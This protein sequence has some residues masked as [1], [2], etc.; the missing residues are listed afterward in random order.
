MLQTFLAYRLAPL[1]LLAAPCV[2]PLAPDANAQ[3]ATAQPGLVNLDPAYI[4]DLHD[5]IDSVTLFE[6]AKRATGESHKNAYDREL[7]KAFVAQLEKEEFN[8]RVMPAWAALINQDLASKVAA[9]NR[10]P[11]SQKAFALIK[12]SL[13]KDPDVNAFTLAERNELDRIG[14]DPSQQE[15]SAIVEKAA[16]DSA[17][18]IQAWKLEFATALTTK[19]I[20]AID[21]NEEAI[22]EAVKAGNPESAEIHTIRFAPWDQLIV[23]LARFST[24]IGTSFLN[25]TDTYDETD[26]WDVTSP[27]KLV[28]R[29]NYA[30]ALAAQDKVDRAIER[31]LAGM[32]QSCRDL[33]EEFKNADIMQKPPIRAKFESDLA[34]PKTL[35][36]ELGES[37]HHLYAAQRQMITFLN[38]R[39]G[40]ISLAGGK[41]AYK[42][43]RDEVRAKKLLAQ[44]DTFAAEV[45]TAFDNFAPDEK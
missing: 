8:R 4:R 29:R 44:I 31:T 36:A 27:E 6:G 21:R 20:Q 42:D 41:L 26:Y 22:A 45:D 34:D 39:D 37:S 23:A 16:K 1:A 9:I 35:T 14:N 18:F 7:V 17:P 19:A 13:D 2:V 15:Y 12:A 32:R 24:G 11:V 30:E 38:S 28:S 33:E 25:L 5:I 40:K 43:K 10:L 3:T